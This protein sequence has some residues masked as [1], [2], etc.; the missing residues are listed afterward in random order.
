MDDQN[1]LEY[2]QR[3]T[4]HR[5]TQAIR[6]Q[7]EA[8]LEGFHDLVPPE[9]ISIFTPKELKL[10]ISGMPDIDLDDLQVRGGTDLLWNSGASTSSSLHV[11]S[12][13]VRSCSSAACV[14][15]TWTTFR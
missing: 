15:L 1:K 9:L 14:T 3:I 7:I 11:Y 2:V 5:M 8:F 4:H 12:P 10:L 6:A 13:R